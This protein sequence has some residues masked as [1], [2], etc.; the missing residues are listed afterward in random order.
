MSRLH[1]WPSSLRKAIPQK[2]VPNRDIVFHCEH[3]DFDERRWFVFDDE[4]LQR[5]TY[6]AAA[7]RQTR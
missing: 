4:D 1:S 6:T 2:N 7:Y 3:Y 5:Y